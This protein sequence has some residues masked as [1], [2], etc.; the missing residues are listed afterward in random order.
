MK[1]C[2]VQSCTLWHVLGRVHQRELGLRAPTRSPL[3]QWHDKQTAHP[4]LRVW[5]RPGAAGA[6]GALSAPLQQPMRG[7][8]MPPLRP[9]QPAAPVIGN[10]SSSDAF[11][12]SDSPSSNSP[13][14]KP[15]SP[16]SPPSLRPPAGPLNPPGM[17]GPAPMR[18]AP[19]L[20][21]PGAL[22]GPGAAS[23][24][25]VA[26]PAYASKVPQATSS[27]TAPGA[28]ASSPAPADPLDALEEEMKKLLGR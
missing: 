28:S 8:A 20:Q 3:P 27:D 15:F 2:L 23:A 22:A 12:G 21:G 14:S 17:G 24:P 25:P 26:S 9:N 4:G 5:P 6:P 1:R 19:S 11:S 7:P 10:S 16:A 18:S 13:S